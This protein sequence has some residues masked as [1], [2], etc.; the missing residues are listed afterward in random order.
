M[1]MLLV[2]RWVGVGE[3]PVDMSVS[4]EMLSAG[5]KQ[6]LFCFGVALSLLPLGYCLTADIQQLRKIFLGEISFFSDLF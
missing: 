4:S 1:T 3:K 5:Q 6:Q 2:L